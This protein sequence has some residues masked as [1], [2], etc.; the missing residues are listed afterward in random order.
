MKPNK[1]ENKISLFM[2]L[3]F[4]RRTLPHTIF[5]YFE[6]IYFCYNLHRE[7]GAK[8]AGEFLATAL[9][10]KLRTAQEAVKFLQELGYITNLSKGKRTGKGFEKETSHW[11]VNEEHIVSLPSY[12]EFCIGYN[13]LHT[14]NF[15]YNNNYNN[16]SNYQYQNDTGINEPLTGLNNNTPDGEEEKNNAPSTISEVTPEGEEVN[17]I[18]NNYPSNEGSKQQAEP[19]IKKDK[20]YP[21]TG[22][23]KTSTEGENIPSSVEERKAAQAKLQ[24]EF[25]VFLKGLKRLSEDERINKLESFKV[26]AEAAY[27]G[28]FVEKTKSLLQTKYDNYKAKLSNSKKAIPS[29]NSIEQ[30][31]PLQ[32]KSIGAAAAK[33]VHPTE[34]TYEQLSRLIERLTTEKELDV[35][36]KIQKKVFSDIDNNNV[37]SDADRKILKWQWDN[38][39]EKRNYITS[40]GL[41]FLN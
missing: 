30:A 7:E 28:V 5:C 9:G 20:M 31:Q 10:D 21:S 8:M 22:V 19:E 23:S 13:K 32:A 18:N 4:C 16:N 1:E 15:A 27:T 38:E 29:S 12:A 35:L 17:E 3:N 25:D 39:I 11:K 14:Q 6:E 40:N 36:A 2:I 37:I 34:A 41:P 33:K 24:N 26:R